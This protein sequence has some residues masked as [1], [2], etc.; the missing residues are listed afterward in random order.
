MADNAE[1]MPQMEFLLIDQG[2]T[3]PNFRKELRWNDLY[4]RLAKGL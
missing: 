3:A 4:Y 2:T 1:V